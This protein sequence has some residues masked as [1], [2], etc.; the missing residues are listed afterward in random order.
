MLV[1]TTE[2]GLIHEKLQIKVGKKSFKVMAVEE[3]KD[4]VEIDI[5]EDSGSY[6]EEE[7]AVGMDVEEPDGDDK[8]EDED[9][10]D[11]GGMQ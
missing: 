6:V 8:D 10:C 9:E 7:A 2:C 5:N 4:I 3:V 11:G 1:H